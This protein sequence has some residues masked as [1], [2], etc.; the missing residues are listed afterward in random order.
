MIK[1]NSKDEV[2]IAN[3]F[4]PAVMRS[5]DEKR[6]ALSFLNYGYGLKILRE[7]I[8]DESI[9]PTKYNNI[10]TTIV[11]NTFRTI[12]ST[13]RQ[14]NKPIVEVGPREERI[15]RA[16][17]VNCEKWLPKEELETFY[18]L[19]RGSSGLEE[20]SVS[21]HCACKLYS[22]ILKQLQQRKEREG[23]SNGKSEYD[24]V[25]HPSHEIQ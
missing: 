6:I 9:T 25:D 23:R 13:V 16:P 11:K 8:K 3:Y 19:V 12:E 21:S 4:T 5:N 1:V 18:K 14:L 24:E 15:L 20:V 10:I 22:L 2:L 17:L 7:V